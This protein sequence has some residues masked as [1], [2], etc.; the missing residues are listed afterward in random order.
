MDVGALGFSIEVVP[1]GLTN[2]SGTKEASATNP[3]M[4]AATR[5]KVRTAQRN[6]ETAPTFKETEIAPFSKY[7]LTA[8]N[9][10][11]KEDGNGYTEAKDGKANEMVNILAS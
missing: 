2:L 5:I 11:S 7:K 8:S 6:G 9:T 1:S 10:M 4:A 3:G